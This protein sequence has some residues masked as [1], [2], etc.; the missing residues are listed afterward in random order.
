MPTDNTEVMKDEDERTNAS[1][2][3][4]KEKLPPSAEQQQQ[5]TKPK[6]MMMTCPTCPLHYRRLHDE[7]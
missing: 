3:S 1:E 7:V 2:K 4:L 5:E 6:P